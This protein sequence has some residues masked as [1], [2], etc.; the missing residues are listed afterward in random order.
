MKLHEI[1]LNGSAHK[2]LISGGFKHKESKNGVNTLE[3]EEE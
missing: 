1:K 3:E 2:K